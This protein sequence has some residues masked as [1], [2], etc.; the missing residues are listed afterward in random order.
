MLYLVAIFCPPLALFWVKKWGQGI[1]NLG[2][3]ILSLIGLI[4]I[5]PGII[6][7]IITIIHAIVV[8]HGVK[9]D[10]RTQKVVDAIGAQRGTP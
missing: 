4:F 6:L 8:V 7:I 3:C 9:A 10:A 5:I 2:L 1:V